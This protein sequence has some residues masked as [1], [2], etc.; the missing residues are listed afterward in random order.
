[1]VDVDIPRANVVIHTPFMHA[2]DPS[3]A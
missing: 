2:A 1:L 3:L